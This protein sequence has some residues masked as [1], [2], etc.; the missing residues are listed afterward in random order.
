M[1]SLM[2]PFYEVLTLKIN[3][4]ASSAKIP[5]AKS[6]NKNDQSIWKSNCEDQNTRGAGLKL[7]TPYIG[8]ANTK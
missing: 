4:S 2:W 1:Q 6:K 7:T 5:V 8:R 3:K